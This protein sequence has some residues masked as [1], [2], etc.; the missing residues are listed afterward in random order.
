MFVFRPNGHLVAAV[1]LDSRAY[2]FVKAAVKVAEKL[3]SSLDLVHVIEPV[4]DYYIGSLYGVSSLESEL[5][6]ELERDRLSSG[7]RALKDLVERVNSKSIRKSK[8]LVGSPD[9]SVL[10]YAKLEKADGVIVGAS[11]GPYGF[12]PSRFS[13]AISIIKD[14]FCPVIVL[15]PKMSVGDSQKDLSFLLADD[16]SEASKPAV[17]FTHRL[18]RSYPRSMVSHAHVVRDDLDLDSEGFLKAL[19]KKPD[20]EILEKRLC[21]QLA[22]RF[23]FMDE[24]SKGDGIY[25]ACVSFGGVSAELSKLAQL[26]SPDFIVFGPHHA[27]KLNPFGFGAMSWTEILHSSRPVILVPS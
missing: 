10:E 24:I 15:P 18:Q 22:M 19:G 23:G 8:V 11:S 16:L 5:I 12:L 3:Q 9:V 4:N 17:V 14:A 2:E 6:C 13:N 27:F 21:S 25:E 7:E 20:R 26:K 1:Q